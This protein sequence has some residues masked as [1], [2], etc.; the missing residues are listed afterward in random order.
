MNSKA[1]FVGIDLGTSGCRAIAID[2]ERQI[3]G[4]ARC[5][6][7]EPIQK[8]DGFE[9]EPDLWWQAVDQT[10]C[11]L[12]QQ[13]PAQQVAAMAIDGTSGTL[14]LCDAQG[15]PIGPALMYHD[16]RAH[17]EAERMERIVPEQNAAHGPTSGLAKLLWLQR[18]LPTEN[19]RHVCHQ[20]DWIVGQL[21]GRF[22]RSD[23]NNSLKL[24]YDPIKRQWPDWMGHLGVLREWL[25]KVYLPGHSIG[26]I[27]DTIAA[28]FELNPST[29]I[30]A[31]TTDSTAAFIATGADQI[32]EAVT[33]LGSTMVMK[34]VSAWPVFAPKFGIYSQPLGNY[35]LVGGSSNSGGRVLR[36]YFDDQ[37][38]A[39]LSAK[40]KPEKPTEL[41]YYPLLGPGERFPVYDP[42]LAPRVEPRPADDVL[43]LQGLLE[44][45]SQIEHQAY[46][47]LAELGAPYPI[48]IRSAGGGANNRQW[49]T[50][51]QQQL[52][53]EFCEA[54]QQEA[55]YGSALLA[56]KG[57]IG[58]LKHD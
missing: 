56:L 11:Q 40:I 24:G 8:G 39:T 58:E 43:F 15:K 1:L 50:I 30:I 49:Q 29:Q 42:K 21:S 31:G 13:I 44:G 33:S 10:L 55:A 25:P 26:T 51:R 27:S 19:V 52:K 37:Q 20:A 41:D 54:R 36:H 4:E 5:E 53:I 16:A 48:S 23:I 2:A 6:M 7:P 57:I 45:M 35:W 3:Q 46:Q 12:F 38:L 47:Q 9:Q 32:G 28:R 22:D 17:A 18:C 14:L 34:V